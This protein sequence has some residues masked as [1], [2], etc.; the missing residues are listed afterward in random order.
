MLL[1]RPGQE[2]LIQHLSRGVLRGARKIFEGDPCLDRRLL[3]C[4]AEVPCYR[5]LRI[6]LEAGAVLQLLR[7]PK[8]LLVDR[9]E[10]TVRTLVRLKLPLEE[11]NEQHGQAAVDRPLLA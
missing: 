11:V 1:R 4:K 7:K 9:G 3:A 5:L 10:P 2:G 8:P 6:G